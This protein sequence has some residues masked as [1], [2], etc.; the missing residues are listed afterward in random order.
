MA[1]KYRY[2][3]TDHA[4]LDV[5]A[6]LNLMIV[7]VPVLLLTM[8]FTQV[9]VLEVKLPE[10][11]GGFEN[12]SDSQ[13]KLE[14]V[15]NRSSIDVFYPENTLVKKIPMITVDGNVKTYD[16]AQLALIMRALKEK[17]N[18]KRDLTI[19][20]GANTRYQDLVATMDAVKSYK[21]VLV[22]SL[23]EV[24]LFPEISLGDG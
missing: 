2:K 13:S 6:F 23:V 22:S 9:T 10:L 12:S 21:T 4:E 11:T 3:G 7:L 24:E 15:I 16:F 18:D 5:T 14:V 20:S 1:L 17:L 8:T 19:L